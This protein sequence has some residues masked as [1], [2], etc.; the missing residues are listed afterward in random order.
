MRKRILGKTNKKLSIVGFGGIMLDGLED[1]KAQEYVDYA[2]KN[3][4]NYFD[5]SPSYGNAEIVLGKALEHYRKE[6]FLSCKTDSYT[7]DNIMRDLERSLKRLKTDY[8]DLYQFH[9]ITEIREV[10]MIMKNGIKA[11]IKA[12]EEGLIKYLGFSAHSQEAALAMINNFDFDTIMFP[13]NFVNWEK[14]YF[15]EIV[16]N[17]AKD[18][19]MGIIAI[20]TLAKRKWNENEDRKGFRTWYKPVDNKEEAVLA[21]KFTLSKGITT[22]ISPNDFERFTWM[23]EIEKNLD[24]SWTKD[25]ETKLKNIIEDLN[26][27]FPLLKRE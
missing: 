21:M 5:V 26:P 2:I 7:Y 6:V 23:C 4:V 9:A 20:K 14:G 12:K 19:K 8:F 3:G 22:C 11:F 24:I 15:G 13:V 10:D 25:D 27:V 1:N 18:E 16:L 17:K